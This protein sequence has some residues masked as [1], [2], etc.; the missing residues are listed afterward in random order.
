[1]KCIK[2]L[3]SDVTLQ[4]GKEEIPKASGWVPRD[5]VR[6]VQAFRHAYKLH[7]P[8]WV[9]WEPLLL[10]I[11]EVCALNCFRITPAHQIVLE[12]HLVLMRYALNLHRSVASA[13][14]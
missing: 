3:W 2:T 11:D 5:V 6:V 7:S 14:R 12:P 1:M 10:L 13:H 4:V 9:F 8:D